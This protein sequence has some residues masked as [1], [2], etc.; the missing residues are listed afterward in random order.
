M[1]LKKLRAVLDTVNAKLEITDEGRGIDIR[2][3]GNNRKACDVVVKKT[4]RKYEGEEHVQ[5]YNVTIKADAWVRLGKIAED[6]VV[7]EYE[8]CVRFDAIHLSMQTADEISE[9]LLDIK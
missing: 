3:F 4:S 8:F 6:L 1:K 2:M 5:F 7:C 9:M